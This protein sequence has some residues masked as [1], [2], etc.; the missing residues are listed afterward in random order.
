VNDSWLFK[1]IYWEKLHG[2]CEW[3]GQELVNR[4]RQQMFNESMVFIRPVLFDDLI[5]VAIYLIVAKLFKR[6][7]QFFQS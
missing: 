5:E 6:N 4:F 7:N 1:Y 2:K 3:C